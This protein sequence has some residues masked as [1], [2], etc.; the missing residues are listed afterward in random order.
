[1]PPIAA[2]TAERPDFALPKFCIFQLPSRSG[3]WEDEAQLVTPPAGPAAAS[4]AAR[5]PEAPKDGL[6]LDAPR[7]GPIQ[8]VDQLPP[9]GYIATRAAVTFGALV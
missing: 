4:D 3:A 2:M 8:L 7:V 1:M 5:P 9:S 6:P